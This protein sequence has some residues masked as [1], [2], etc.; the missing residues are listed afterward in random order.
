MSEPTRTSPRA[1]GLHRGRP[2]VVA[3]IA[4]DDD[5][6]R[7]V[8]A[9]EVAV[10]HGVRERE[11]VVGGHALG[12]VVIALPAVVEDRGRDALGLRGAQ[13]GTGHGRAVEGDQQRP[14]AVA[15][16]PAPG[17]F[18]TPFGPA[19]VADGEVGQLWQ[20]DRPEVD[21]ADHEALAERG[22]VERRQRGLHPRRGRPGRAF[23]KAKARSPWRSMGR[24]SAAAKRLWTSAG[25]RPARARASAGRRPRSG[26][27]RRP[28]RSRDGAAHAGE[29]RG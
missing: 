5:V 26:C 20:H 12:L 7:V 3:R 10:A 13:H 16:Q 22:R 11:G 27:T 29:R 15:A 23:G 24:T 21:A 1:A 8:A 19:R 4:G 9:A 6:R 25:A 28:A 2:A 14:H 17:R 18:H